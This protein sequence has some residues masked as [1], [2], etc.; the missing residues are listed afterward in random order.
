[1]PL[2]YHN[3]KKWVDSIYYTALILKDKEEPE[4]VYLFEE[5]ELDSVLASKGLPYNTSIDK[6][7]TSPALYNII[8]KPLENKLTEASRIYYAAAGQ[9]HLLNFAAISM[10]GSKTISDKYKLIQLNTTAS[11]IN[12]SDETINSSDNILLYG[13]II[14][15]ADSTSLIEA[16]K[17]YSFDGGLATRSMPLAFG[18]ADEIPLL[19]GTEVEV[20]A[21]AQ[22]AKRVGYSAKTI[23][24]LDANEESVKAANGK[25]SS[26]V[27]HFATHGFFNPNPVHLSRKE[28]LSGGKAFMLSSDP[29]MRSGL[30]L[31]GA[32]NVW[33]GK[34]IKGIQD[35]I[36]TGYEI[37]NLY[38]PNTKLVV[39]SACE[40][41][42]GQIEGSEGVYGLQRAFKIAG[43]QNLVMSLWRIPDN[44]TA[45][46]MQIFYKNLFAKK[47]IM[48]AFDEAQSAMKNKYRAQPHK[49]AGIILIH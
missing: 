7:Y 2:Q 30:M 13:G 42:L 45:E 5:R 17:K 20:D 38:L 6:L 32:N 36:L 23:K 47:S 27:F 41:G 15:S 4:L 11:V 9:L 39:L 1:M 26:A 37:S 43:T 18:G 49:W 35:G 22:E 40:T 21:I 19:P 14:Y 10:A 3:G 24:G 48:Q 16:S 8:W 12:K 28:S 31:A 29:L 33:S 46:F 25:Q 34:P 44:T